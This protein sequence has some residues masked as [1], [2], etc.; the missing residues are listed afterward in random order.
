MALITGKTVVPIIDVASFAFGRV[1]AIETEVPA[2]IK[3]SRLPSYCRMASLT[4]FADV[5]V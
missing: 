5:P 2:V 4:C 1:I 3:S